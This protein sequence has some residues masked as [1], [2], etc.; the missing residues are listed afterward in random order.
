[1]VTENCGEKE[2]KLQN[3]QI[4]LAMEDHASKEE[5]AR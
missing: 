2:K 4:L 1:M 3:A 5:K